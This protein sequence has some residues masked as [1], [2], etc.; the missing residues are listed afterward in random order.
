MHY[1]KQAEAR[2]MLSSGALLF[3]VRP[4]PRHHLLGRNFSR[5]RPAATAL[6]PP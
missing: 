6:S 3:S 1:Q 4:P 5:R 2:F